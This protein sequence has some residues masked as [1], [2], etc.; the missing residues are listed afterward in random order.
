MFKKKIIVHEMLAIGFTV[1]QL[2][3]PPL[4]EEEVERLHLEACYKSDWLRKSLIDVTRL[5]ER[6]TLVNRAIGFINISRCDTPTYGACISYYI[7]TIL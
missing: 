2:L 1:A 6:Q 3:A 5:E 4:S 7:S